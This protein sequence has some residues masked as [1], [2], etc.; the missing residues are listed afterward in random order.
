MTDIAK[1]H[2]KGGYTL[3]EMTFVGDQ[4]LLENGTLAEALEL[5][6]HLPDLG[7][8]GMDC[9]YLLMLPDETVLSGKEIIR[10]LAN[11]FGHKQQEETRHATR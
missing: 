11:H 9:G 10:W 2:D 4:V 3:S 1:E 7:V 6:A 5:M 8:V